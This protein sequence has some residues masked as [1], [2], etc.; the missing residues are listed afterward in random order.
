MPDNEQND[1]MDDYRD[2]NQ[3]IIEE[4]R[5]NDGKVGGMYAGVPMLLL[6]TSGARSGQP[7]VVP[8][9]YSTDNGRIVVIAANSGQP[10][11]PAWYHNLHAN[12][13]VTIELGAET[14]P[15]RAAVTEGAERQRL[16]EKIV[17]G[18]PY[19]ADAQRESPRQFP[20]VVL[21]RAS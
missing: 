12:P 8:L 17:A 3:K 15:A 19:F 21:D 18:I 20:M 1:T 11:H 14:F 4:V 2:A 13:D 7:R 10:T 6:T 16:F 9:G 5:A